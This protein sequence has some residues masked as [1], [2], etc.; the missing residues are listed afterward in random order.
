[1]FP[2]SLLAPRLR[3]CS[4]E[5]TY[6]TGGI[7]IMQLKPGA[8]AAL[9]GWLVTTWDSGHSLDEDRFYKFVDQYQRDHGFSINEADLRD[10]IERSA[11]AKGLP[12]GSHQE[13]LIHELVSLAYRILDFLRATG[14]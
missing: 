13:N 7:S 2:G 12:V 14:R 1:V 6:Q 3:N 4:F 5:N 9:D 10:E 8:R 11:V